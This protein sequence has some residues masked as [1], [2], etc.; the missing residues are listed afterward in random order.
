MTAGTSKMAHNEPPNHD[1]S[2]ERNLST[3]SLVS[4]LASRARS[5]L[6]NTLRR[7]QS[8]LWQPVTNVIAITLIAG[9]GALLI[10][11]L[12][13]DM[14]NLGRYIFAY[15]KRTEMLVYMAKRPAWR[16][17]ADVVVGRR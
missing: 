5:S 8:W 17:F 12:G 16:A 14:K 11:R 9:L 1:E 4:I 2:A 3:A 15:E 13:L 7:T 10:F 6:R